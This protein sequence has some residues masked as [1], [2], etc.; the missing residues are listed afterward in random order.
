MSRATALA[1]CPSRSYFFLRGVCTERAARQVGKCRG[2][3]MPTNT[4]SRR[5]DSSPSAAGTSPAHQFPKS[6]EFVV[7]RRP[8]VPVKH[9][10]GCTTSHKGFGERIERTSVVFNLERSIS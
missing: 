5:D 9:G 6:L 1:S 7:R 8:S 2:L 10:A 4:D 3:S